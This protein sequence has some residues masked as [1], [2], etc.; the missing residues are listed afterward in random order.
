VILFPGTLQWHQGV[1]I[2]LRAFAKVAERMP[3]ADFHI[4][5][6][7]PAAADLKSLTQSLRLDGR[8]RFMETVPI[9]QIAKVMASADLGLVPKRS[10]S[11]GNEAYSTKI[12]EFMAV[13]VPVIVSDTRIDRYYF[14]DSVVRFFE[15]GNPD[16]L[17]DAILDLLGNEAVRRQMVAQASTY[18]A[19]NSWESRKAD[20]INLVDSLIASR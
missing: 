13:G 5:G 16:A 4:Y 18:A 1:D 19:R 8:V 15:S 6:D 11:F 20:Y 9:Q 7:G 3:K 10:D 12:M 17:A 14:D 2:A